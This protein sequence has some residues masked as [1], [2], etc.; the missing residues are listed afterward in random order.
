[1]YLININA[2]AC[3]CMRTYRHT[4]RQTDRQTDIRKH[5]YVFTYQYA[6]ILNSRESSGYVLVEAYKA[7]R[8][9]ACCKR[10][11]VQM[12]Q[13]FPGHLVMLQRCVTRRMQRVCSCRLQIKDTL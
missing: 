11:G 3:I 12:L 13:E 1:M 4:D 9:K 7:A 10:M 6:N 5:F 2:Y 8:I